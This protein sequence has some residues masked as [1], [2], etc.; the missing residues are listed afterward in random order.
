MSRTE[1]TLKYCIAAAG[2]FALVPIFLACQDMWDGRFVYEAFTIQD[3]GILKR[4]FFESRWNLQYYL[5]LFFGGLQELSGISYK[6]WGNILA[7]ASVIGI[8]IEVRRLL[9]QKL[10]VQSEFSLLAV[11]FILVFP[12]W[13]T[14]MSSVLV[15]H[16]SCVWAFLLATRWWS[17]KPLLAVV[18]FV[19]SLS[20][21]SIF[22][23]AVGYSL[24]DCILSVTSENWRRKLVVTFSFCAALTVAFIAYKTFYPP[25]NRFAQYNTFKPWLL[26]FYYVAA[27]SAVLLS[28]A[29]Y[30][31]G[32]RES[33]ETRNRLVK[34]VGACLLLLFFA[35]VAYWVVGK[36]IKVHGTNSFTPRHA[37]LAVIPISMLFAVLAQGGAK[38]FGRL[39]PY[40]IA[41]TFVLASFGYQFVAYQQKYTQLLYENMMAQSLQTLE[42]PPSGIVAVRSERETTPKYLR[43]FAGTPDWVF[44]AAYGKP[45]WFVRMCSSESKCQ[46]SDSEVEQV[47]KAYRKRSKPVPETGMAK[48]YMAFSVD[49]FTAFGSPVYYYYYFTK[50]YDRFNPRISY[51]NP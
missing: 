11:L 31:L 50:Q 19:Y 42:A 45:A 34:Q 43:D 13:A 7:C 14:L 28:L 8:C 33:H 41:G 16:I 47:I 46:I 51:V 36:P 3:M 30:V 10:G 17:S 27:L 32:H 25:Y 21:N 18:F 40:V 49:G 38:R 6:I 29:Y 23:F 20:L 2:F 24:F 15:F 5:Y 1:T 12:P 48:S 26:G 4:W 39:V 9:L 44:L 22:A 35:C 37:Y